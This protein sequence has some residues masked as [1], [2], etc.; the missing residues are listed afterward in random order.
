MAHSLWRK[1]MNYN[2]KNAAWQNRDRFVLSN[3]H[4]CA[5]QYCML[6]LTGYDLPITELQNFRQLGSLTPGH[7]TNFVTNGIE[8][9]AGP[10]GQGICNAVGFAMA[11][12]HLDHF[13]YVICGDRCLQE[14]VT[15]ASS[16]AGHLGLGKL[17]L[18]YDDNNITIDRSNDISFTEDVMKRYE[19][20]GW[21]ASQV[22]EG[23]DDLAGIQ[24]AAKLVTDKPSIISVKTIIGV[25]STKAGT[26][27][28]YGAS[29]GDVDL[30]HV[31]SHFRLD[32]EK[33]FHVDEDVYAAKVIRHIPVFPMKRIPVVVLLVIIGT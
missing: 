17:I 21:D 28:V 9:S 13:T 10:I 7:P 4:A 19:A 2:P 27:G 20:Y 16:L 30:A 8:V 14:V 3:G 31:K 26:H 18:L 11:E 5:L 33:K 15:D 25:G 24:A 22:V 32:P 29:L 1:V 6:H 23:N 12:A